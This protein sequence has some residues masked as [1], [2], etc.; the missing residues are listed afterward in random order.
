MNKAGET[1]SKL[2]LTANTASVSNYW[3]KTPDFTSEDLTYDCTKYKNWNSE[4]LAFG[5]GETLEKIVDS[6]S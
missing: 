4:S 6:Y 1:Y 2:T 3:K 5:Q